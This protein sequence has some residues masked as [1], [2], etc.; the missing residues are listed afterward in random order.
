MQKNSFGADD[1]IDQLFWVIDKSH[2]LK[3]FLEQG[4]KIQSL[5]N[6]FMKQLNPNLKNLT[7]MTQIHNKK[8]LQMY[9]MSR[10]TE[11]SDGM[12]A[13]Q[14]RSLLNGRP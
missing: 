1:F 3:T 4:N 7:K 10:D 5:L 8:K 2:T 14:S 12:P 11:P 6:H 9:L 13:S